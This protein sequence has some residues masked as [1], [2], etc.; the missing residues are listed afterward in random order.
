MFWSLIRTR[1]F[2]ESVTPSNESPVFKLERV[3]GPVVAATTEL[4]TSK[5]LTV[6]STYAF[7]AASWAAV[8]FVTLIILLLF[9]SMWCRACGS[10]IKSPPAVVLIVLPSNLMLS[11]LSCWKVLGVVDRETSP[12]V[13][14][15]SLESNCAIPLFVVE[16]SSSSIVIVL[17]ETVVSIPSPPVKVRSSPVLITS[18]LPLSALRVN[19]ET[20]VSNPNC[21]APFVFKTV[22]NPHHHQAK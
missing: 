8:G 22:Q 11:T 18:S 7:V 16:A 15:K 12:L 20:T 1:S 2:V 4:L 21:P 9:A 5:P 19:E 17:F 10:S 6:A 14:S 3:I 13:T